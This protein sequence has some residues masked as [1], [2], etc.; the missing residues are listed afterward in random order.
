MN[1]LAIN[2][3][4]L[5]DLAYSLSLGLCFAGKEEVILGYTMFGQL[6]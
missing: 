5:S 6:S 4:F 3:F 1:A 2:L